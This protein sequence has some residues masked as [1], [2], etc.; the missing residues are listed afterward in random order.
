MFASKLA[1]FTSGNCYKLTYVQLNSFHHEMYIG[2]TRES[3]INQVDDIKGLKPSVVV[4]S[5]MRYEID[6]FDS[7]KNP[8]I[9]F[10]CKSCKKK[11]LV[12]GEFEKW[13]RCTALGCYSE[14]NT[15]KSQ[16]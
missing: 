11:I 14:L 16:S 6:G 1:E 12:T 5:E 10:Y 13:I 3:T 9:F 2:S 7:Y 8:K 4:P 15:M